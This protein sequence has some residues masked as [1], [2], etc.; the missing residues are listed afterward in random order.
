MRRLSS[1]APLARLFWSWLQRQQAIDPRDLVLDSTTIEAV[2]FARVGET[3]QDNFAGCRFGKKAVEKRWYFGLKLH[4]AVTPKGRMRRF[5]LT[6]GNRNDG[7]ELPR[8][9]KAKTQAVTADGGYR[10]A[11][12]KPGVKLTLT[13]P[14]ATTQRG[15]KLNGKRSVVERVFNVLKKLNLEKGV[16]VKNSRSLGSHVLATLVCFAAIQFLNHNEGRSP[17]S[18]ARFLL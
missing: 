15:R 5:R 14:W 1:L 11:H 17:L 8:L 18:Y 7:R 2:L 13:Q 12:P 9:V 6:K 10:S 3:S 16:L 4:L